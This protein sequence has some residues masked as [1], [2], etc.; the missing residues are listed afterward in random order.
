MV[1][2]FSIEIIKEVDISDIMEIQTE[3][4]LSPWSYQDYQDE[5]L[6]RDSASFTAKNKQTVIGFIIARLIIPENYNNYNNSFLELEAEIYNLAVKPN[7][8]QKGIGNLLL[9]QFIQKA[10]ENQVNSIWLEVRESNTK[11][12]NFYIKNGFA[13]ISER[14]NYY[15]EPDEDAIIMKRIIEDI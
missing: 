15:S 6:R 8:Q 13:Q 14:K 12:I 7:F 3:C 9:R 2:P 11:A 1:S 5:I 10:K 4:R